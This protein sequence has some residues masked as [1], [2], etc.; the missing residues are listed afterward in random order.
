M[1]NPLIYSQG[2]DSRRLFENKDR[3]YIGILLTPQQTS[4]RNDGFSSGI[5][6]TKG[7]AINIT[8]DG[9]FY[10]S[11]YI[12]I[13]FGAGYNPYTSELSLSSYSVDYNTTD[14]DTPPEN[15]EMQITGNSITEVQNISFLSIPVSL[16][17]RVPAGSKFG[18]Y[19][20]AGV[21][22]EIP[23]VKTYKGSGTFTYDGYYAAYPVTL[24]NLPEYGFATNLSTEVTDGLEISSFNA[25]L[26]ASAGFYFNL[27]ASFQVAFGAHLN[28]FLSDISNYSEEGNFYLT[29]KMNELNSIMGGST[30]TSVQALGLSLGLRYYIK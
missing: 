8:A 6:L 10:F 12:G 24:H 5:S 11:K 19:V 15:Y 18:L 2:T 16:A 20:T 29:K 3:F 1:L 7:N 28:K 26:T 25:A 4:I 17:L 21:S 23:I 22:A 27:G 14:N 9:A 13:N 30:N